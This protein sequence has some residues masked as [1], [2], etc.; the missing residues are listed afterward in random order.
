MAWGNRRLK[1]KNHTRP[2]LFFIG[3]D[4]FKLV[5]DYPK[6]LLGYFNAGA[7]PHFLLEKMLNNNPGKHNKI[8]PPANTAA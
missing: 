2:I 5:V 6:P 1:Q 8:M 7:L 3:R 4:D